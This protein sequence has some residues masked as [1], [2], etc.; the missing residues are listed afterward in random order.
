MNR[1][2]IAILSFILL[3]PVSVLAGQDDDAL[4]SH[5]DPQIQMLYTEAQSGSLD[6]QF[7]LGMAYE[8]G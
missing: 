5:D 8:F 4:E 7:A 6:A 2:L 1:S 3:L